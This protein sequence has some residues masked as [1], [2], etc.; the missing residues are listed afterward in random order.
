MLCQLA[1]FGRQAT[2]E[3]CLPIRAAPSL[4]LLDHPRYPAL[5]SPSLSTGSAPSAVAHPRPTPIPTPFP[6][7][8]SPGPSPW[9]SPDPSPPPSTGPG[10]LPSPQSISKSTPALVIVPQRRLVPRC[11][12]LGPS[13]SRA[14]AQ[15]HS[16]RPA[17]PQAPPVQ[18]RPRRR[19]PAQACPPCASP[20]PSPSQAQAQAHSH[21]PA[22]PQAPPVQAR[23]RHRAPS[24]SLPAG[25]AVG[26][27]QVSLLHPLSTQ[28]RSGF[29][30]PLTHTCSYIV[31]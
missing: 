26:A 18:A 30:F 21:P 29:A 13:P 8:P 20:G 28:A 15:A 24:T 27:H 3:T 11:A 14:Q 19:A 16:H 12:S 23:P 2:P 1:D 5:S 4:L 7:P 10:P 31:K 25:A 17:H 9:P 22:H 6:S